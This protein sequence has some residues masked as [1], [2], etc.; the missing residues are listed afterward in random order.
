MSWSVSGWSALGGCWDGK[1]DDI[2]DDSF[3]AWA[4]CG[5]VFGE[6]EGDVGVVELLQEGAEVLCEVFCVADPAVAEGRL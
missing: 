3:F 2:K 6:A 4:G 1:N 5:G